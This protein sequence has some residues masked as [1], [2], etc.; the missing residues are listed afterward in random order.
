MAKQSQQPDQP[1]QPNS[2]GPFGGKGISWIYF[3]IIGF[4]LFQIS[5]S[6]FKSKPEDISLSQFRQNILANHDVEKIVVVNK[7]TAEV[8]IK[9]NKLGQ[10]NYT[11]FKSSQPGPHYVV[12]IGSF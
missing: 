5:Y 6:F 4:L 2:S 8:F 11:K 12:S 10:G 9:K 3:L 7:E 1:D